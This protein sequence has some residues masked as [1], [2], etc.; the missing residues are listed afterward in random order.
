MNIFGPENIDIIISELK[1]KIELYQDLEVPIEIKP[2]EERI[3]YI[4]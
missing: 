1:L 3:K 2:R 4:I